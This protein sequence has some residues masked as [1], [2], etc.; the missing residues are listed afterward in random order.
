[1][2]ALK[3][4]AHYRAKSVRAR[5]VQPD[6]TVRDLLAITDWD[7]RW[8]QVYRYVSP[9]ML[10]KGTTVVSEF[11]YDNSIDNP[12]NPV[13]PPREVRWGPWSSDE[14]GDCWIQLLPRSRDDLPLLARDAGRKMA[15]MDLVGYELLIAR[16]PQ[17]VTLRDEAGLLALQL[18]RPA[19]AVSQFDAA[20]RIANGSAGEHFN[21]GLALA[22][23]GRINEA[24]VEYRQSIKLDA[25]SAPVHDSLGLALAASGDLEGARA[26]YES[27]IHL[28]PL[29]A[30]ARNNLGNL[31]MLTGQ[32]DVAMLHFRQ[33]IALDPLL[34][35]AHYNTALVLEHNG[36]LALALGEFR[37]ASRLSPSA[38]LPLA[39]IA[40]ILATAPDVTVRRPSEAVAVAERVAALVGD[41][42]G[43][44]D[45]RAAAHAAAGRFDEAASLARRARELCSGDKPDIRMNERERH[46]NRHEPYYESTGAPPR[47]E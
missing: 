10:P 41:T 1:V 30:R 37:E 32:F 34:P 19:A 18:G 3:P 22:M 4:H 42:C 25:T 24:V 23:A 47:V 13:L 29:S 7:M 39:G 35:D 28:D 5:A 15:A 2:L 26:E 38:P 27:A 16:D 12:R 36:Q 44:L 8:Q 45:L 33:A 46:Y 11:T 40:W 43:S 20:V 9:V 17:N 31:L 21:L 6:G 14:M